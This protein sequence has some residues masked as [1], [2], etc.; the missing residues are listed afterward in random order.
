MERHACARDVASRP[1]PGARTA[2]ALRG[3]GLPSPPPEPR[4][5]GLAWVAH[6]ALRQRMHLPLHPIK[7]GRRRWA[8]NKAPG[9]LSANNCAKNARRLALRRRG[10][11]KE[12]G[13][14]LAKCS[15]SARGGMFGAFPGVDGKTRQIWVKLSPVLAQIGPMLANSEGKQGFRKSR[16]T[17]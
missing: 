17:S 13:Q 16:A 15:A 12:A 7:R 4:I 10:D 2:G 1:R 8:P 11:G 9:T 14:I 5:V 3:G 6:G